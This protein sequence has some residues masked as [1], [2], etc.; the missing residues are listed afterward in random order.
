MKRITTLVTLAVL[1]ALPAAAQG[2]AITVDEVACL[3]LE[4]NEVLSATVNPEVGG[5]SVRLYFRRLNPVGEFYYSEMDTPGGGKYW[6]PFPKPEEKEQLE[7]TDEWWE[8]LK[9]RDWME[10]HDRDWLEELLEEEE[11]EFAEYYVAV[12]AA[13]GTTLSRS[14]MMLTHVYEEDDCEV[15]LTEQERGMAENMTVGETIAEQG[16]SV[17]ELMF[18]VEGRVTVSREGRTVGEAGA[19]GILAE[20][21]RV[22]RPFQSCPQSVAGCEALPRSGCFSGSWSSTLSF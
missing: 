19:G 17:D 21:L 10:G 14:E 18:V 12:K 7:L 16:D 6:T 13:D 2:P 9:D 5:S 20:Q 1:A 8:V 3:P 4:D 11:Y 15:E 22:L